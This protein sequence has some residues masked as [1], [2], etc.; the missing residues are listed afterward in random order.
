MILIGQSCFIGFLHL[1][2]EGVQE[3]QGLLPHPVT[4]HD[5]E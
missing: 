2:P 5:I 4:K 3:K 1:S